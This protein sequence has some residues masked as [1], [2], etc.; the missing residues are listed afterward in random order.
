MI[1]TKHWYKPQMRHREDNM[2]TESSYFCKI[3]KCGKKSLEGAC[4]CEDHKS[5]L[6][7]G[8]GKYT[9]GAAPVIRRAKNE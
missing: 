3:Y 6:R 7:T 4:Y 5:D 8:R 1:S 9:A 2:V